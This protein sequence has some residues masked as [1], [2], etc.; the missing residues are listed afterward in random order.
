MTIKKGRKTIGRSGLRL[1]HKPE[2]IEK[3]EI[4]NSIAAIKEKL[5]ELKATYAELGKEKSRTHA[6]TSRAK[7]YISGWDS[8]RTTE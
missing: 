7:L 3:I 6:K 1:K 2:T 4:K 5:A 8:L